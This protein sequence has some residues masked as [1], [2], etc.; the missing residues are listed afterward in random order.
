MMGYSEKKKKKR[1]AAKEQDG[2]ASLVKNCLIGVGIALASAIVLW[3]VATFV[4]YSN[5]DPDAI[6]PTLAF[7]VIYIVFVIG[8]FASSKL[9]QGQGLICGALS[10]IVLVS[11]FLL[12]SI[13]F[14]AEYSSGYGFLTALLLRAAGVLMSVLGG[15]IGAHKRATRRHRRR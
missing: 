3:V 12:V 11:F 4:A 14:G 9:N 6:L 1:N 7:A 8:G 5:S 15:Y 2:F 13:F 10:G